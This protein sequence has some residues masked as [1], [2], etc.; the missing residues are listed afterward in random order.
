M[1]PIA[2]AAVCPLEGDGV[3][4]GSG[5]PCFQS[6]AEHVDP[7]GMSPWTYLHLP[8]VVGDDEPQQDDGGEA[9]KAFQGQGEH[10]VLQE[11]RRGGESVVGLGLRD[12]HSPLTEP[13][14]LP[15]APA[16]HPHPAQRYGTLMGELIKT[17]LLISSM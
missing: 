5:H 2:P 15:T 12:P 10:G 8:R 4:V 13:T 17:L 16:T 14:A 7:L 9:D 1:G 3:G 11:E 6:L